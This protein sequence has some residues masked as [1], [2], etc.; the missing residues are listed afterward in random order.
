MY[1]LL[2]FTGWRALN[3]AGGGEGDYKRQF[4]VWPKHV[5]SKANEKRG[6]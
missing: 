1:F 4:T 6:F 5:L 3:L 2:L